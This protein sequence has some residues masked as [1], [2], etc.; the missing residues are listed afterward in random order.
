MENQDLN[1]WLET[2]W[3]S[4][5]EQNCKDAFELRCF[6]GRMI[7]VLQGLEASFTDEQKERIEKL[8]IKHSKIK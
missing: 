6:I 4:F 5:Q 1:K 3:T 7:G 8:F 2:F